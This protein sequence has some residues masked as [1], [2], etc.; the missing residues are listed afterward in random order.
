[1]HDPARG[2]IRPQ[3]RRPCPKATLSQLVVAFNPRSWLVSPDCRKGPVLGLNPS[4]I[5]DGTRIPTS[6]AVPCGGGW[7]QSRAAGAGDSAVIWRQS[8]DPAGGARGLRPSIR[9]GGMRSPSI[10]YP[11]LRWLG[12]SLMIPARNCRAGRGKGAIE[13]GSC[14]VARVDGAGRVRVLRAR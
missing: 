11:T 10:A 3:W 14:V 12:V 8:S 9:P 7:F 4:A 13:R 1:M 6:L 2:R 5:E